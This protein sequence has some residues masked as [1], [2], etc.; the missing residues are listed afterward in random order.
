VSPLRHPS[1]ARSIS[2]KPTSMMMPGALQAKCCLRMNS[3]SRRS[4]FAKRTGAS[5]QRVELWLYNSAAAPARS[6]ASAAL[7]LVAEGGGLHPR[8]YLAAVTRRGNACE[9]VGHR[10]SIGSRHLRCHAPQTGAQRQ[11][12]A[13]FALCCQRGTGW[14]GNSLSQMAGQARRPRPAQGRPG[15]WTARVRVY[16]AS[17]VIATARLSPGSSLKGTLAPEAARSFAE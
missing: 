10:P 14:S 17:P 3:A 1:P 9:T 15:R 4:R 16:S 12:G 6:A 5:A 7:V 8:D 13:S 11:A 2:T